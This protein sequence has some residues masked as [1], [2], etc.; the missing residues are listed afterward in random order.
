M[1]MA[2]LDTRYCRSAPLTLSRSSPSFLVLCLFSSN[3]IRTP[4]LDALA[5]QGVRL[6]NY[7]VQPVCSP[8]RSCIMTG[9]YVIHT[10]VHTPFMDATQ[11][12]LLLDEVTIAQRL[13]GAGDCSTATACSTCCPLLAVFGV[14]GGLR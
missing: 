10:G 2:T 1:A 9:R 4:N 7:Y 6:E 5:R 14:D 12:A 13:K 3:V 8:T 11:N